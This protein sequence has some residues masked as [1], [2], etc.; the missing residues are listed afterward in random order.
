MDP[1]YIGKAK[2]GGEVFPGEHEGIVPKAL[3]QRVQDLMRENR[4]SG[5]AAARNKHGALLRGLLRCSAC[6]AAMVHGWTRKGRALYRYYV[7]DRAAKRGRGTCPTKSVPAI[8]IE[9]FVVNQ[10]RAIGNDPEV[11]RQTFAQALAQVATRKQA[12]AREVKGLTKEAAR[13]RAE[14]G[15]LV[16]ATARADG[17]ANQAILDRLTKD[18]ARLGALESR[19]SEIGEQRAHLEATQID[20]QEVGRVLERFDPIWSVLLT[21]EKERILRLLIERIDYDGATGLLSFAFRL[22]GIASLT[23]ETAEKAS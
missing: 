12:L 6:D 11:R 8:R 4:R 2:L 23:A 21:Q 3:F 14:V 15:R 7:C 9:E 19:L 5:G 1:I 20:E 13:V 10:I 18:Q 22:P 16:D 17:G